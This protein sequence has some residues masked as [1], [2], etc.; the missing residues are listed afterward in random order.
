MMADGTPARLAAARKATE[1]PGFAYD[2]RRVVGNRAN[3]R[4]DTDHGYL[5][6]TI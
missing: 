2:P 6:C 3:E 5:H 1:N 4:D